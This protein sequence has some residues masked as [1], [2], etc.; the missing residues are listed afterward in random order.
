[1]KFKDF[2]KSS[3][4]II[5]NLPSKE[6]K[7]YKLSLWKLIGYLTAYSVSLILIV[8]L[9][10]TF[11]PLRKA[12]FWVD[13]PQIAQQRQKIAKLETQV[14]LLTKELGKVAKL[15]RRLKYAI[16]LAGTDSLDS[17][18]AIYDTLKSEKIKNK[19]DGGSI[20]FVAEKFF[21]K[22]VV[23]SDSKF[24]QVDQDKKSFFL[25]SP[26][27][28]TLIIKEFEPKESHFGIDF[29]VKPNT[30]IF[31]PASGYVIFS[32]FTA[33]DGNILI[34]EHKNNFRTILKHCNI[35]LKKS[36]D[37]VYQGELVAFSGNSG[38]NTSGPHLHLELWH[39]DK[40]L[41]PREYLIK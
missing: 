6:M 19:M 2:K 18:A 12:I 37:K 35:L 21:K 4:Y 15:D 30:E 17:S 26:V 31:S 20:L 1:M 8:F 16:I 10:F 9:L 13:N 38:V 41:N 22:F 23:G 11:S 33:L 39:G 34:I 27:K 24:H 7:R 25:M 40:I 32:G 36:G 3:I 14:V 29:A 28:K 5:P